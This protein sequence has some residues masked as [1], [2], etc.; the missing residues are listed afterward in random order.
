MIKEQLH[1]IPIHDAINEAG[2]CPFCYIE[3]KLEERMLDFVLGP[4]SSYMEAD[5]RDQT[6]RA[7]FCRQH[8]KKMFDYGNA[9]GNAWILKTHLKRQIE[10]LETVSKKYKPGKKRSLFSKGEENPIT[11]WGKKREESCYICDT[12][13]QSFAN[14]MD[15]FFTLY[16]KE[17]EF[18]EQI[19]KGQGFCLTHFTK[20]L[21]AADQKLNA[22]ELDAF[23]QVMIP[24]ETEQL[25]RVYEDVA[26]FIEK[27]D[28]KNRDADWKNSKDANQRGMQKLKGADPSDPPY[29]MK[30]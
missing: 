8:F 28:Y 14:Y 6:D 16:K 19:M 25:K 18:R 24:F 4:S 30:K 9:L 20:L 5:I 29:V 26:W 10:E 3:R 23:Y 13:K 1:T 22:E 21:E 11:E 2:E 7:G 17:S 27:Y 15:T 12:L